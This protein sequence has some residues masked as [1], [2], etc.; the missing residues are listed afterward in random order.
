MKV[1][2]SI[3]RPRLAGADA[4][5]H[6][7]HRSLSKAAYHKR[8]AKI[9]GFHAAHMKAKVDIIAG[10]RKLRKIQHFLLKM[11]PPFINFAN[12]LLLHK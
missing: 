11:F 12:Q 9:N 7:L 5:C 6:E 1:V 10:G 3:E 4:S 8:V 2:D